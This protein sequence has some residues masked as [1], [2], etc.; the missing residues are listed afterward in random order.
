MCSG[1]ARPTPRRQQPIEHRLLWYF[2]ALD[3]EA[4]AAVILPATQIAR[5]EVANKLRGP[6]GFARID[7]RG[8]LIEGEQLAPMM[9]GHPAEMVRPPTRGTRQHPTAEPALSSPGDGAA[10]LHR[11]THAPDRHSPQQARRLRLVLS[12]TQ[13]SPPARPWR[14][15]SAG[16]VANAP[17]Q[18]PDNDRQLQTLGSDAGN[19]GAPTC[20]RR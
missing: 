15:G 12:R 11:S 4:G 5:A 16:P 9:A 3:D 6:P 20:T 8:A 14:Q 18:H 17:S 1:D 13:R 19:A 7:A 2:E 10:R